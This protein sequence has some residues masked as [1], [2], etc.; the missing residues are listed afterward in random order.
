MGACGATIDATAAP[1]TRALARRAHRVRGVVRGG[2]PGSP[3][4]RAR[5]CWHGRRRDPAA[6]CRRRHPR[7]AHR[8]HRLG[9]RPGGDA[10]PRARLWPYR[11]GPLFPFAPAAP[12]LFIEADPD[13]VAR[14]IA[15]ASCAA[16]EAYACTGQVTDVTRCT[17]ACVPAYRCGDD[18]AARCD[19]VVE[20]ANGDDERGCATWTCDDGSAIPPHLVC[21]L[22]P[23]CADGSD[24]DARCEHFTCADGQRVPRWQ[25]CDLYP[26][27]AGG[28]D[29]AGCAVLACE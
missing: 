29:E 25:L 26:Q 4:A 7:A 22:V 2:M 13:C 20:C 5:R 9:H 1:N 23:D 11:R 6:R 28:D 3:P 21:D 15:E 10:R 12:A 17:L 27:C 19:G 14:C 18:E 24:E 16:Y 8:G